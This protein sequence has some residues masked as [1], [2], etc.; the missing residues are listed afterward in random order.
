MECAS[1]P[2]ARPGKLFPIWGLSSTEINVDRE[3]LQLRT[4]KVECEETR[5]FRPRRLD[6]VETG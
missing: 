1:G 6:A 5:G 4:K 3:V 2:K